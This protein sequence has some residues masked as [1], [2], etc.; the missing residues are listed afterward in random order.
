MS[1]DT[2]VRIGTGPSRRAIVRGAAWTV[3]V[4]AVAAT[5]PA[6]AASPCDTIVLDDFSLAGGTVAGASNA[7]TW[8]RTQTTAVAGGGSSALQLSAASGYTG[9][10]ARAGDQSG[11]SHFSTTTNAGATGTPGLQMFQARGT[12]NVGSGN[13][14][15]HTGVYTYTFSRAVT[16]LEFTISDIDYFTSNNGN[17]YDD[18]VAVTSPQ[19]TPSVVSRGANILST[20]TG[21][22]ANP[23]RTSTA[24][25]NQGNI[26]LDDGAGNV[27]VRFTGPITSFSITYWNGFV[28]ANA[29]TRIQVTLLSNM[30]LSYKPCN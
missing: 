9:S 17:Q 14:G 13:T 5:A 3:P 4:V 10:M 29:D 2:L 28:N 11:Y 21:T 15:N 22:V 18:R 20:S 12:A 7:R 8:T 24:G 16:D 26:D 1:N 27:V 30:S 25:A 6:Y 23:F 19:G